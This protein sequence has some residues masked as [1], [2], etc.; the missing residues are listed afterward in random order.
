[1]ELMK[2]LAAVDLELAPVEAFDLLRQWKNNS[3]K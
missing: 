1:M 2:T 3:A